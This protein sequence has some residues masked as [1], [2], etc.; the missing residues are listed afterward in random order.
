MTN[1]PM[2]ATQDNKA[3]V[4]D[5]RLCGAKTRSGEPCKNGAMA[6]GRCRM[7]G[8]KSTG[9]PITHGRYSLNH[10]AKLAEK[11]QIFEDANFGDLQ[12]ELNLLRALLQEYI[13]RF[14]D[15][16]PLKVSDITVMQSMVEGIGRM[17]ERRVK[18]KNDTAFGASE[19]QYLVATLKD[20]I[21]EFV[22]PGRQPDA[23]IWL[24]ERLYGRN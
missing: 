20:F 6:N 16:V 9:R 11:A 12:A 14:Y 19:M 17:E 15:G 4:R 13:D 22:Q 8:G 5:Q 23:L 2:Q 1:Y 3:H 10:R 24:K 21:N 7:H 18:I